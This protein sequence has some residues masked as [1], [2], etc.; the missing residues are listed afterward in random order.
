MESPTVAVR[1]EVQRE[2]PPE[3]ARFGVTVAARDPDRQAALA[4]VAER[5]NALRAV[6][7]EYGAAIER[8]E[9]GGVFVQP[10]TK[11]RGER[12]TAYS[13]RVSTTVTVTDL[14]VL[15][16]IMLR[17]ADQDQTTVYGPWWSLRPDSPAYRAARRD[18]VADAVSRARE[19]ADA[20]GARLDR[21]VEIADVGADAQPMMEL[22]AFRGG[23]A[24]DA[25]GAP[26]LDLEPPVQTVFARVALRFTITQ[27]AGDLAP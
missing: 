20:V 25:E 2:V 10:E 17:L 16:D 1:G 7:D 15:G 14:T 27:P 5:V 12:V 9:T 19:Y 6:L 3:L 4:R 18:A 8:R 13:A 21:L 22:A 23:G 24:L 11:G 26:R